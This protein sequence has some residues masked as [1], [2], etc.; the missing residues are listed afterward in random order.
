MALYMMRLSP[1]AQTS[2]YRTTANTLYAVVEGEGTTMVEGQDLRVARAATWW[3]C[4]PGTRIAI[5]RPRGAVLFRVT[6][7]PVMSR[8]GFLRSEAA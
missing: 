2:A 8:L 3:W 7:E 6:D 5:A 1:G 4:R